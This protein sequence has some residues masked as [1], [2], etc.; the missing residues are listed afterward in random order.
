VDVMADDRDARI[1]QL[2]AENAALRQHE[3]AL[4]GELAQAHEQQSAAAE[5]LRV[6]A[7]SS[8]LP[9]VLATLADRAFQVVDAYGASI[10]EVFGD[11]IRSHARR[12][13]GGPMPNQPTPRPI[14]RDSILGRAI[15]DRRPIHVE[16]ALSDAGD[17]FP[18][19]RALRDEVGWR[20]GLA[21]PLLC[22]GTA[23]GTLM[24]VR[25]MVR[26]FTNHEIAILES[27]ADQAAI[28]IANARLFGELQQRNTELQESNRQVTEALEQQTA[29]AEVLRVL[30]SSPTKLQEVLD[31]LVESAA[32]LCGA[33]SAALQQLREEDQHFVGVATYGRV[34][35]VLEQLQQE[36]ADDGL[37]PRPL[38]AP[39]SPL[40][41]SGRA[42][43]E[44]RTIRV[45][46]LASEETLAEYPA[47]RL[48]QQRLGTR[49]DVEMPLLRGD[50]AIG[51]LSLQRFEVHPF[52]DREV[53]LLETFA[54]QAVIAIEN[55]RL[56]SEL[57]ERNADL[58]ESNRRVQES[59]EQ[60]TSMAEVLRVIASSPTDLQDVLD[61]IAS[62]AAR[63]TQSAGAAIQ[64]VSG[65][66]LRF[67]ATYG[68]ST[69]RLDALQADGF[70][71]TPLSHNS[72]SGRSFLDRRTVHVPDVQSSVRLEFT[73]SDVGARRRRVRSQVST[74][75]VR[76][77]QPIGVLAV[78]RF[79]IQAFTD[80]QI[81]LLQRL[82]APLIVAFSPG[83]G[84]RGGDNMINADEECCRVIRRSG[85][86]RHRER[87]A[88]FGAGAAERRASRA[89]D[90]VERGAGAA[91][92]HGRGTQGHQPFGLRPAAGPRHA[93]RECRQAV[94][95]RLRGHPQV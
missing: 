49:S 92:R 87:P 9:S 42:F 93:G 55:A 91:D 78:H 62:A 38:D 94:P 86:H 28:A 30:A 53:E 72:I 7:T 79:E 34:R 18:D 10:W 51:I 19:G 65:E 17:E 68:E 59:L 84:F 81:A 22:D 4:V 75:L 83:H 89:N 33:P 5:V 50:E 67:L 57:E 40:F 77:G 39:I 54:D 11:G 43:L 80:P 36:R 48:R 23:I 24:V 31:T 35:E 26:P 16:D 73:D 74:P 60:Q 70:V 66:Y 25:M 8:D 41:V 2:E 27:F 14:R 88:L 85:R 20:T 90:R 21:V 12:S 52:T 15:L 82:A 13:R 1:A 69:V 44:R 61:S 3:A 45:D 76:D 29:T 95:R 37:A 71:G 32:R 46:D 6:I 58:Q 63:L 56:F 64:E 47:S